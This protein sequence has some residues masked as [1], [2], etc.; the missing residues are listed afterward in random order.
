M[1]KII[2]MF[3]YVD[4]DQFLLWWSEDESNDFDDNIGKKIMMIMVM[5]IILVMIMV[6]MV[7]G[8]LLSKQG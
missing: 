5:V 4:G 7:M 8:I 3:I 1:K 2:M 6:I